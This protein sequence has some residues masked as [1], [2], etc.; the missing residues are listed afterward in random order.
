[1]KC[2]HSGP[3]AQSGHVLASLVIGL[4]L[5]RFDLSCHECDVLCAIGRGV[6]MSV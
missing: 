4:M 2:A 1:M 5:C 3:V 6:V